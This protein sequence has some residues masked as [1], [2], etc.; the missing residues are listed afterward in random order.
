MP[1]GQTGI[2]YSATLAATGGTPPFT[3]T[4]TSGTLPTGLMLNAS[5]GAITGTTAQSVTAL[6]LTFQVADSGS[7]QQTKSMTLMLTIASGSLSVSVSPKRA[8]LT[9][10]QALPVTGTVANDS[11][12]K[13]VSWSA[14]GGSFSSMTSASGTA[15]TYTAPSAAG[16]YTVTA[17]SVT[18]M[19][20]SASF[21]VGV[22]NLAGVFTF[23]NDLSRDG[24]N[25]SEY[26]LTTAN[27]N[28]STFAKLFSC[29]A[30]GAIY[31]QPL[32]VANFAI[33]G[34]KHNVVV[35]ATMR[36]SV[37][38]F[39]ADA[40]PCH[41]YWHTQFIPA[42]ETFVANTD[43]STSD[44]FPDIGILGTPVIDSAASTIYVVTK[45]KTTPGA[46]I[47]QRLHALSLLDGSE[48]AHS[49]VEIDSTITVPGN[50]EGGASVAFNTL[51]ENQRP[52]LALVNGVAYV[53]WASHG[54]NDPYHGW[55]MGYRTSDLNRVSVFNTSPS[56]AEGLGYC[57]AGIW[58]SGGAPAADSANNLYVLTGNGIWDGTSAF[59]D[60][61][62]KLS[63]ASGLT[64]SDWFTP[65]NQLSL[66][67]ND[68][69]L[70]SGGAAI[71][72]DQ[73]SGPHPHLLIGGGKQG[74]LYLIDRTNLG[75]FNSGGTDMVVQP[76]SVSGGSFSTPAF[77]NNTLFY[78]GSGS[79]GQSY[80]FLT[81]SNTFS[82]S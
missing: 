74:V 47:H 36:D 56:A 75:H 51:T 45:T 24:A 64:V 21:T 31:A 44:I 10:T 59:G 33:G 49:P 29:A 70:G 52:G 55:I 35:A 48:R 28:T 27:V 38:V 46:I 32:W 3:W 37:Y 26:A 79:A 72:V 66:D 34:A 43:V 13:G 76:L 65:T 30:D 50:C 6:S 16:V 12:N 41:I 4:L 14:S 73:A 67:G 40:N 20:Q 19:S 77:W 1:S 69:D 8:G 11:L 63:T 42:G 81:A 78:F 71:L 80:S 68:T 7:P 17:T 25:T 57:R 54:D 22:T 58:M 15:V 18:D 61:I 39:D 82:T 2:A 62:L 60:S 9:V 5:T 53:S 23:H